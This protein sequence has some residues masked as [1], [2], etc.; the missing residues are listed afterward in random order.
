MSLCTTGTTMHH[1]PFGSQR[2]VFDQARLRK[3]E[4]QKHEDASGSRQAVWNHFGARLR[5]TI[6]SAKYLKEQSRNILQQ[7]ASYGMLWLYTAVLIEICQICSN[8]A[9]ISN[10]SIKTTNYSLVVVLVVVLVV[11]TVV[12]I[13][14]INDAT[15]TIS[16][17][18]TPPG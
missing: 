8:T 16:T 1:L 12:S 3:S 6:N 18:S 2:I 13:A 10:I 4:N 11:T 5:W 15:S 9:T 14:I 17:V 7:Q